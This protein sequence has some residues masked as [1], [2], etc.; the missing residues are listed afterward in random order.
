MPKLP[1]ALELPKCKLCGSDLTFFF[2]ITFPSS[3]EW[4]D[5]MMSLF[6]CT[7]CVHADHLIPPMLLNMMPHPSI[8]KNFLDDYQVNFRVFIFHKNSSIVRREYIERVAFKRWDISQ[9]DPKT[10]G[11]KIGGSPNWLLENETPKDYDG[12]ETIFLLQVLEDRKFEFVP[13]APPQQILYSIPGTKPQTF[14]R[15]FNGNRL[16]FFGTIDI[17]NP[18]VYIITQV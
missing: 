9:L 15:L 5:I 4:G 17:V 2:Q 6:A 7:L 11:D 18:K 13:Q 10:R 1:L 16:F 12:Q 8:P 14:Y 3:S